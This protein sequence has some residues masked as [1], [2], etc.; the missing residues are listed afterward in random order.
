MNIEEF[1]V[2]IEDEIHDLV[3]HKLRPESNYRDMIDLSQENVLA[4]IAMVDYE[5]E[6]TLKTKD[7]QKSK[8]I[9]E[10]FEIIQAKVAK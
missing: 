9:Q 7:F 6:V 1:I 4:L 2:K 8:T 10:L 5:F 3:P